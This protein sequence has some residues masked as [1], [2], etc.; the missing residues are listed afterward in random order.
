MSKA[1]K[2][3]HVSS[4]YAHGN[5]RKTPNYSVAGGHPMSSHT[6]GYQYSHMH[7]SLDEDLEP[8]YE[9]I[10]ENILIRES[11]PEP[12]QHGRQGYGQ[13]AR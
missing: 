5:P 4:T 2:Q 3:S 12:E 13:S 10:N 7:Q 6:G 1:L 11:I 8:M 9:E